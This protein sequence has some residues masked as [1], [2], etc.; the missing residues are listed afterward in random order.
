MIM[1][2]V[3]QTS[4][5]KHNV[6]LP[7]LLLMC[8]SLTRVPVRGPRDVGA[9]LFIC[10]LI[11]N[12][13][14]HSKRFVPEVPV[15]LQQLLVFGFGLS[16][17]TSKGDTT[18]NT[19]SLFFQTLPPLPVSFSKSLDLWKRFQVTTSNISTS[20]STS[21]KQ[22]ADSDSSS[23]NGLTNSS[24]P[25]SLQ[26]ILC[27]SNSDSYV[28]STE[29]CVSSFS[30]TID[31]I[32]RISNMYSMLPSF[33]EIMLPC[34]QT[35]RQIKLNQ[36]TCPPHLIKQHAYVLKTISSMCSSCAKSRTP[37]FQIIRSKPLRELNPSFKEDYTPGKDMDPD[38]HR[39]E[40]RKLARKVKQEKRGAMRE[41]R[42][43]AEFIA[44]ERRKKDE[45][46]T[47]I[48]KQ[49]RKRAAQMIEQQN[50]DTNIMAI[51]SKKKKHK[52]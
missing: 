31:L 30:V 22:L 35:L 34:I 27:K 44:T 17:S 4:D 1:N 15:F 12:Y 41:L 40:Q 23:S 2:Y 29:F 43:D 51:A 28:N 47:Q 39:V 6:T 3:H 13:I 9:S 46:Q 24:F 33:P 7:A 18:S 20:K 45:Q 50:K 37:L 49:E 16:Q 19:T 52:K 8:E 36:Q 26:A 32:R 48:R 42:R 14:Q 10:S 11:I 25:L 21:K 5:F 38:K